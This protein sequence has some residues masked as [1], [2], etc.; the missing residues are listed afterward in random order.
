MTLTVED[1]ETGRVLLDAESVILK[2]GGT[3]ARLAGIYGA[4]RSYLL[5][6]YLAG[7]AVME[8]NGARILNH[9]HHYD[10][11]RAIAHL[12]QLPEAAGQIFNVCDDSPIS[13]RETYESL[14]QL[15][16]MGVPDSVPRR[17]HSKR[18]WS[19][20]AVSNAKLRASGWKASYPSFVDAAEE[21]AQ[22]L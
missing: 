3:V 13:Q 22:S 14:A 17:A 21:I 4:G 19:S 9:I 11:A 15:F 2:S 12:V 8:E 6:K 7:E 16:H 1:R 18:G 5:R 20:K 10:A